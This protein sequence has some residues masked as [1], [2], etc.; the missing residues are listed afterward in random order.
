MENARMKALSDLLKRAFAL[1]QQGQA[2]QAEQLYTDVLRLD[3]RQFDALHLLGLLHFQH[4]HFAH[5]ERLIGAALKIRP[6]S[7]DATLNYGSALAALDRHEDA[8]VYFDRVLAVNPRSAQALKNRGRALAELMRFD[9]ALACFD[10]ALA[11]DPNYVSCLA[12]RGHLLVNIG[13]YAEA[14]PSCERALQ[15]DPNDLESH[16]YLSYAQL[17]LG[18]FSK[19]W[20]G[21]EWRWKDPKLATKGHFEL[22][23]WNGQYLNGTILTFGEQGLGDEIIFASM[24]PDLRAHADSVVLEVDP[25]L[26]KLLARSIADI[27]VIGRGEPVPKTASVQSPLGSLGLYLR[28]GWD[29]FPRR[30]SGYLA[31]DRDRA[32]DLRRRLSPKGEIVIGVSWISKHPTLA[33][34]KSAR[35]TDFLPVLQLPGCRFIDLQYGDT[36]AER[37]ALTRETGI[38]V[39]RQPDIDNFN[40]IDG[41]AALITACDLVVTVSNTTAHLAGALGKT[42]VLFVPHTGKHWAWFAGR[43]DS[44]WYPRMHISFQEH[45]QTWTDLVALAADRVAGLVRAAQAAQPD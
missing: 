22:P 13:R 20:K 18:H 41:L 7:A 10:R 38:V 34:F 5:A 32:A 45:G 36:L 17:A 4:Q 27:E 24:V 35:L 28:Q 25:R 37:E 8:I 33:R 31:A 16:L 23:R 11:I 30:D 42:T 15:F 9:E 19:G 29:S 6:D 21:Y 39:E 14:I 2:Q 3:P 1:H 26:K 43:T 40:D 44:P 12:S